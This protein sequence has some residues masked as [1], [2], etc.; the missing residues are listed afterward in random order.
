[1]ADFT[2]FLKQD[3]TGSGTAFEINNTWPG[4]SQNSFL[5]VQAGNSH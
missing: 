1:M 3:V 5:T 4:D 2:L